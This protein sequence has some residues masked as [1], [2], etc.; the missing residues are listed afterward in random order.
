MKNVF[1]LTWNYLKFNKKK[2]I[3]TIVCVIL[4]TTLLNTV[5]LTASSLRE[6]ELQNA[7]QETG[8]YHVILKDFELEKLSLLK[9]DA[10]E[11][12]EMFQFKDYL[13][14]DKD[15]L[16]VYSSLN[17]YEK[18]ITLKTG[19]FPLNS[20]E[21][22]I[23]GSLSLRQ[24]IALNEKIGGYT[25]VGVYATNLLNQEYIGN[26]QYSFA[27][28]TY[29]DIKSKRATMIVTLNNTKNAYSNIYRLLDQSGY[30]Y[31]ENSKMGR[32]YEN[33]LI[34]NRLLQACGEYPTLI[35][36]ISS[37]SIIIILL[38]V[39]SLF[40]ILVIRNSFVISLSER[41]KQFGILR[42]IGASK[43]QLFQSVMIEATLIGL[44]SIPIGLLFSFGL[45]NLAFGVLNDALK[46]VSS[47]S[48]RFFVY[49]SYF[50]LSLFFILF[51]LYISA[52]SPSKKA[53]K[54]TPMEA[55]SKTY[56][57]K[58]HKSKEKNPII[59]RLFG[60]EGE[61]AYKNI[62]RN[63]GKFTAS[64][65]TLAI[66]ILLF[67]VGSSF[68]EIIL[69]SIDAYD[70]NVYDIEL[71]IPYG[72]DQ[73]VILQEINSLPSINEIIW[74]KRIFLRYET[75][76]ENYD[77]NYLENRADRF[78]HMGIIGM[79]SSSYLKLQK[80][81]GTENQ[82]YI[83]HNQAEWVDPQTDRVVSSK[84]F[85]ENTLSLDFSEILSSGEDPVYLFTLNDLY[86]TEKD[87][88]MFK[89]VGS[90]VIMDL[91]E[92][93]RIAEEHL[94][95]SVIFQN[96]TI[97]YHDYVDFI[98]IRINSK[99]FVKFD[100]EIKPIINKYPNYEFSYYNYKLANY[101][102][103]KLLM[104]IKIVLYSIVFLI[105][106][107][108]ITSMLSSLN[109][110]LS[111]RGTEFAVL[112]SVGLSKKGL[113][114]MLRLE[115]FFLGFYSLLYSLPIG[116]ALSYII[117]YMFQATNN[118]IILLFPWKSVLLVI[119]SVLIVIYGII[120]F[121]TKK[122]RKQNI[123]ETIRNENI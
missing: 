12:Y 59:H 118:K 114:K 83:F 29:G 28:Y 30:S 64:I 32:V 94:K 14:A 88:S 40:C 16:E 72:K 55:I 107:V 100:E 80:K 120:L 48:L 78:S 17:S 51:T 42:S 56:D 122:I 99:K 117:Q 19:R 90:G 121:T 43:K 25:V 52:Y 6:N 115:G 27:A 57:Y 44:V 70:G 102:T 10:I 71:S 101:N 68:V 63:N 74:F 95:N 103:Y 33:A 67:V 104:V 75:A 86:L 110:S 2:T 7:L 47:T 60:S 61:I 82:K 41:K 37:Y 76:Y 26:N 4:A 109:A 23:S 62:K 85:K 21:I 1:G 92:Y 15:T 97:P 11:S 111:L 112:R 8:N 91:E 105:G 58:V 35:Q 18:Y 119:I 20:E 53:S 89:E 34:N 45:V 113:R 22:I 46:T 84:I 24:N 66:S 50:I 13:A 65:I 73:E 36:T 123:I 87:S 77:E 116:I 49:P 69:D 81:L 5:G 106:L 93:H 79:D 108:S 9:N 98:T 38:V 96:T 31:T 54:I 3:I 39:I